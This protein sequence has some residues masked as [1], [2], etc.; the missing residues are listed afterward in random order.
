M[1]ETTD[2]GVV[3]RN[4][5][6]LSA[7]LFLGEELL[8]DVDLVIVRVEIGYEKYE[9]KGE[10]YFDALA[11][12]RQQLEK[13]ELSIKCYGALKNVF[14][15]PMIQSMGEGRKAYRL[16]M[17]KQAL[18]EDLVDIFDCPDGN[19][20]D[21]STVEDQEEFYMKWISSL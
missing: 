11:L 16:T 12:V 8:P 1:M 18:A 19:D 14:P 4:D 5:E 9:A 15:S 6:N 2:I 13:L 10:N 17:G 3:T 21:F 20:C 7:K